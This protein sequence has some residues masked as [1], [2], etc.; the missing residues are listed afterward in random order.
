MLSF[1]GSQFSTSSAASTIA[2]KY[3][4]SHYVMRPKI[5]AEVFRR[6]VTFE[7]GE[8][9]SGH[10]STGKNEGILFFDNIFPLKLQWLLRIPFVNVE[11]SLPELLNKVNSPK[12]ATADPLSTVYRAT[13]Y[14]ATDKLPLKV[15][16]VIPRLRE[17]GAFVKFSR[18]DDNTTNDEIGGLVMKHLKEHPIK[19]WFNP[20]RRV[21]ADLVRGKPWVED[22]YRMPSARLRVEYLA[23]VPEANP[24]ELTQE[25]IF[26]LFRRFGKISDIMVQPSD[27]KIVPRYAYID[28]SRMPSAIIAKNCM[29]GLL[30]DEAAGGGK[31]GT[32]LRLTFERKIKIHYIRDFISQHSRTVIPI[33]AA[34][35]AGITVAVFDPIRTFFVKMHVTQTFRLEGNKAWQWIRRQLTAAHKALSFRRSKYEE[36]GLA[37][38]YEDRKASVEQLRTWLIETENTFIVVQGP[39]GSGKR[40]I[41]LAQALHDRPNKVV[42]DC[43]PIQDANGDSNTILAL[44][45]EVGYRPVF[46]WLN[47]ISSLIDL[48]AQSTI[49]TKTGFSETLDGQCS[50]ILGNT[51]T[52]LK[53]VALEGKKKD[54]KDASLAE[55]EYLESHPEKRPV[56]VIDNFLHKSSDSEWLYDKLAQWG[57]ALTTSNIAHVVFL[58]DEVS[59]TKSL[60]KALPDRVFRQIALGDLSTEA[61]KRYVIKHLDAEADDETDGEKRLTPSQ[62]RKDLGELDTC[63]EILGGRLTDLEFLARRLKSGQSPQRAVQEIIEQSASEIIKLYLLDSDATRKWTPQQAWLLI[64]ELANAP[65]SSSGIRYNE[66]LLSD[67]FSS[68]GEST[69]QAL[70]Q[71]ELI[72]ITSQNGRPASVKPGKPVYSAAFR[73]L[74]G[75]GVLSSRMNLSIL[76]ELLKN[77]NSSIAK[78]EAELRTLAELPGR[79]RELVPRMKW[80]LSKAAASQ[81]NVEG[82]EKE[83]AV[84]KNRLKM[85]F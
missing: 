11:K 72:T 80:L 63:I 27:S 2:G 18:A 15:T 19:P 14:R 29:H 57:A 51:A 35:L 6:T 85:E 21:R 23:P 82:Y 16:E 77:E 68:A 48:A 43:K 66:L 76:A 13:F 28:F 55:D 50:K 52:A 81:A 25:N 45:R 5:A 75:D 84:L 44:S 26:T 20:F 8:N 10:I 58:T 24:V 74:T 79:P 30:L 40:E 4:P 33:I 12:D 42:I 56:V 38:I 61:A 47:S 73:Y 3:V 37:A 1:R 36:E 70:E 78:Y 53:E 46:K 34:I 7:A 69:L 17:G 65:D 60:S 83:S 32:M 59:F 71:A 67:L 22:L 41:V 64:R 54:A 39:R 9:K 62:R 49:G 31:L